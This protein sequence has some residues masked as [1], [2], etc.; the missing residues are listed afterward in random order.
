MS[1]K[2]DEEKGVV[3]ADTAIEYMVAFTDWGE[4]D[5]YSHAYPGEQGPPVMPSRGVGVLALPVQ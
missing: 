1:R 5:P 3:A 2:E 4:V